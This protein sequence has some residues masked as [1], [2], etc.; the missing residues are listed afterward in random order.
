MESGI[1]YE[2]EYEA[3]TYLTYAAIPFY[4]CAFSVTLLSAPL[5]LGW[6]AFKWLQISVWIPMPTSKL[7]VLIGWDYTSWIGLSKLP[8]S[9]V[10]PIVGFVTIYLIIGLQWVIERILGN[11]KNLTSWYSSTPL[12]VATDHV[13]CPIQKWRELFNMKNGNA[14]SVITKNMKPTS[15]Q[16]QE[17]VYQSSSM[18]KT[19]SFVR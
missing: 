8:M 5:I 10:F 2:I 6:Q 17:V 16:R 15:S 9:L 3:D 18:C 14:P 19:R 12:R 1:E 11:V 7:M 13:R 4:V